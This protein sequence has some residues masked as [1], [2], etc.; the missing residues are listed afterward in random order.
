MIF[1]LKTLVIKEILSFLNTPQGKQ[2]LILP[3]VIQC[4]LF[5]FAAT[6]E[7]KNIGVVIQNQDNG[8]LSRE[9]INRI[10]AISAIS[11]IY[12][13]QN[14]Q[15]FRNKIERQDAIL[16][17]RILS[18][19]E[20]D[21]YSKNKASLQVILDGR[22]SNGSQISYQYINEVILD[23]LETPEHVTVTN[24]YNPNLLFLWHLMPSLVAIMA[25]IGCLMVTGLS[26]AREKEEGTFDQLLITPVPTYIIMFGKLIPGLIISI[27]QGTLV[28]IVSI[29][30]YDTP[31]NGSFLALYVGFILFGLSVVGMGLLISSLCS[32]QQQAF[33]GVFSLLSPLVLLSGY[34]SPVENMPPVLQAIAYMNP[35]THFIIA[36]KAIMLKSAGFIVIWPQ[37]AAISFISLFSLYG[38]YR[39]FLSYK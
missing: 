22:K 27:F 7:V 38:T 35:L 21:F 37:L 15:E 3:V 29:V 11:N 34:L 18:N 23:F 9:L 31:F 25:A 39:I 36:V 8:A 6:L 14:D 28:V 24:F 5:P 32:T 33:L 1:R 4:L 16:G 17:I 12:H 26:I 13:A 2:I 30:F 19:F 20:K 10:S